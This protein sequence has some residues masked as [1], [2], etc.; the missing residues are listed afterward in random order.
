MKELIF[1]R[2]KA[3]NLV[4]IF[5]F[6]TEIMERYYQSKLLS[7]AHSRDDRF[8]SLRYQGVNAKAYTKVTIKQIARECFLVPSKTER[9]VA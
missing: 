9:G 3:Y 7:V 2:V 6:I 4:Q 8:S 1:S 5:Y